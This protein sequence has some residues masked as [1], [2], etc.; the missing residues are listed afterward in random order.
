M[1]LV[2]RESFARDL[3]AITDSTVLRRLETLID[4]TEQAES[5]FAI[6]HLK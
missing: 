4:R 1:K 3:K 6:P 2:F 5:L